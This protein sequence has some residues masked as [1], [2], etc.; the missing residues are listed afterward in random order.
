M[1]EQHVTPL[2]PKQ[3]FQFLKIVHLM[4][5]DYATI[6]SLQYTSQA[7]FPPTTSTKSQI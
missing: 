6:L 4:W 2:L 7:K 5:K 3:I 1:E